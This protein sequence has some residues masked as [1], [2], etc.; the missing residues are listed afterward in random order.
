MSNLND[1]EQPDREPFEATVAR[2]RSGYE[3][4]NRGDIDGVTR[5]LNPDVVWR[6]RD[7]HPVG[8][9]YEGRDLVERDV[10]K[11]IQEQFIDFR[12]DPVEFIDRGDYV[13]VV[14]HQACWQGR[15]SGAPVEGAIVHVLRLEGGRGAELRAFKNKAEAFAY[16]ES[17]PPPDSGD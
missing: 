1:R 12:L 6:R 11:A 4:F 2:I 3:A 8:G 15:L 10:L 9:T 5:F 13:V 7:Q 14:L 17:L 16:L